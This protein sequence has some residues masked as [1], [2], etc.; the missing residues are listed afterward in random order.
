MKGFFLFVLCAF[1]TANV[2]TGNELK[3][4]FFIVCGMFFLY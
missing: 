3:L 2:V 1:C 4:S